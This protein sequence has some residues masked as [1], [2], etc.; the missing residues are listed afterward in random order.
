MTDNS[1]GIA[2]RLGPLAVRV[3]AP[4][5]VFGV[6]LAAPSPEGLTPQGQRALAVMALAVVLWATE[7]VPIAVTGIVSVVLLVLVLILL[8]LILI[9]L[10]VLLILLVLVLLVVLFLVVP[11]LLLLLLLL[12]FQLTLDEFIVELGVEVGGIGEEGFFV[13]LE[14]PFGLFAGEGVVAGIIGGPGKFGIGRSGLQGLREG[15]LRPLEVV[16]P[17]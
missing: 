11:S 3:L 16:L 12:F 14:G 1:P 7:A 2:S 4:L 6:V 8:V 9:L 10:V 15:R 5:L 17:V 13:M